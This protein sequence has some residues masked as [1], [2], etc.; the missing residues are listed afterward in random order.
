MQIPSWFKKVALGFIFYIIFLNV[1]ADATTDTTTPAATSGTS[2]GSSSGGVTRDPTGAITGD[3]RGGSCD[4]LCAIDWNTYDIL[5]QVNSLPGSLIKLVQ[6][7]SFPL[8]SNGNPQLDTQTTNLETNFEGL[9]PTYKSNQDAA[10]SS[11]SQTQLLQEFFG[12]ATTN[13]PP[14]IPNHNDIVYQTLL[15][16]PYDPVPTGS[17]AN[18]LDTSVYNYIKNV[19]GF[20]MNHLFPS[21]I[22]MR[23]PKAAQQRYT[24]YY[25]TITA[26]QSY[27][28]HLLVKAL[29]PIYQDSQNSSKYESAKQT[30]LK[31]ASSS[32]W[33]AQ[34]VSENIGVVLRQ[35]LMYESQNFV[36]LTQQ[37]ELQ[38]QMLASQSMTN[39][40]IVMMNSLNENMLIRGAAIPPRSR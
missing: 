24:N 27:N 30:L 31:Q 26:I 18:Y 22:W 19:A 12:A 29:G 6:M 4:H 13:V 2:V 36:V 16:Q 20:N 7:W 39:T 10:L 34:I 33:F 28:M 23:G 1:W 37:L 38:R 8:D 5:L 35:M 9:Y 21:P 14:L 17:P 15:G 25:D 32:D 40:L 11:I 3:G